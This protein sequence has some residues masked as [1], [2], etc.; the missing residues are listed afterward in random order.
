MGMPAALPA[1]NHV[2]MRRLGRSIERRLQTTAT[3][4]R[5]AASAERPA[6]GVAFAAT[7]RP[8][9]AMDDTET[10]PSPSDQVSSRR[11]QIVDSARERGLR[12]SLMPHF[13]V[14]QI[15]CTFSSR[16]SS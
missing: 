15:V 11:L 8:A 6:H 2:L 5:T 7:V 4:T 16:A 12:S 1:A 3:S 10:T 9:P 14:P 13:K